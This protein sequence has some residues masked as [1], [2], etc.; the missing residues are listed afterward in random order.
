MVEQVKMSPEAE[1]KEEV[2]KDLAL[3]IVTGAGI[4]FSVY[5][6][7]VLYI[8]HRTAHYSFW[9]GVLAW[10]SIMLIFTGILALL[11]KRSI[12]VSRNKL[13]ISDFDDDDLIPR[14]DAKEAAEEALDEVDEYGR[15]DQPRRRD[16]RSR[17]RR[18]SE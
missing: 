7:V 4:F 6:C 2:R 3:L 8:V 1:K 5:A 10:V 11:V 9:L 16:Y 17:H 18:P 15:A 12:F 13:Y 14:P